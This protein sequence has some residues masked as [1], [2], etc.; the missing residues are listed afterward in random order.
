MVLLYKKKTMKVE[1]MKL[2]RN[3][4]QFYVEMVF[5]AVAQILIIM[6]ADGRIC[7]EEKEL[8]LE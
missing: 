1:I 3:F 8:G 5:F 6:E 7:E 2:E 4:R